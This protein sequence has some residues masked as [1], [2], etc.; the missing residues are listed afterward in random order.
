M[1]ITSLRYGRKFNLGNYESEEI[2][3]EGVLEDGES[4]L[5]CLQEMKSAV[6]EAYKGVSAEPVTQKEPTK[7]KAAKKVVEEEP[8]DTDLEDE[9]EFVDDETEEEEP[10]KAAKKKVT[11][12]ATA[13]KATK[14]KATKKKATRKK[15]TPYDRS[16]ELHKKLIGEMLTEELPNWKK[17]ADIKTA[18]KNASVEMEGEDFLDSEGNI[19]ESFS[20]EFLSLVTED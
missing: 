8:E 14:K 4:P 11:K 9:D 20:G 7:K 19:L 16:L 18:C 10:K 13:K 1:E 2:A 6:M 3:F 5:E 15:N 12:K 17:D